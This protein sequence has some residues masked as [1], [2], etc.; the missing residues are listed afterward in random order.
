[1]KVYTHLTKEYT[2][3][4]YGPFF[5][6]HN[7]IILPHFVIWPTFLKTLISLSYYPNLKLLFKFS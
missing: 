4:T 7:P 5:S 1:M 3:E 2:N 6:G